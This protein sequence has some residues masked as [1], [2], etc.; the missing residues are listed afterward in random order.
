M[1]NTV[2]FRVDGAES[3]TV[4][5][6]VADALK[7]AFGEAPAV[8]PVTSPPDGPHR[9]LGTAIAIA[10]LV[11]TLPSAALAVADLVE[12]RKRKDQADQLLETLR[13]LSKDRSVSIRLDIADRTVSVSDLTAD[14]LLDLADRTPKTPDET[15]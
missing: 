2:T 14:T 15:P 13:A 11:L 8:Q 10:T 6:M 9:D 12:R 5:P 3:E 1:T 7:R 4:A